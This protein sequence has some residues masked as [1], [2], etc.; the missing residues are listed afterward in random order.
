MGLALEQSELKI[1]D[2]SQDLL[3]EG[4]EG[5]QTAQCQPQDGDSF[6]TCAVSAA[7]CYAQDP[8]SAS[9]PA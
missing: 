3:W 4:S 8:E 5:T 6:G 7:V 1:L 9:A 2:S